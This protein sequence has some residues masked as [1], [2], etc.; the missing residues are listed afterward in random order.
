MLAI[1]FPIHKLTSSCYQSYTSCP[2]FYFYSRLYLHIKH[3]YYNNFWP[4]AIIWSKK[5]YSLIMKKWIYLQV[6]LSNWIFFSFLMRLSSW[7]YNYFIHLY[8]INNT[9]T[10]R[11]FKPV[12][13]FLVEQIR[14]R[15]Q[16][17]LC[18]QVIISHTII[19]T[20]FKILTSATCTHNLLNQHATT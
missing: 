20:P 16:H 12:P 9:C 17:W 11:Y 19:Q 6:L 5:R 2:L 15:L 10:S 4:Q 7:S 13:P 18:H 14:Q 3:T 1:T 8:I